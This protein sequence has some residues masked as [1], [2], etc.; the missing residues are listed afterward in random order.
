MVLDWAKPRPERLKLPPRIDVSGV[1]LPDGFKGARDVMIIF[2]GRGGPDRETD[3]LLARVRSEDAAAG[4]QRAVVVFDWRPWF[5]PVPLSSFHG[6]QV[7]RRLGKLLARANPELRSLHVMGTSAG[8]YP[9]DAMATAY[10][11]ATR[12]A[13]ERAKVHATFM[14][15]RTD[16]RAFR[17]GRSADFAEH[18]L[19]TDDPVPE[20]DDP[21]PL[22]YT[23][24]VT[25]AAERASFPLPGGGA[26]GSFVTDAYMN[27]L[28]YHNWPMGYVARHYKTVLDG[29]GDVV[30]PT[31]EELPRGT[32]KYVQ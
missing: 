31:H 15:P 3:D 8:A 1:A 6:R 12:E 17:L 16:T 29:N 18:V 32:V 10:T 13:P 7:G 25:G 30:L 27:F 24:D 4:L 23:L 11:L 5:G 22:C 20:T 14:D 19:N 21:L 9:A 2:H 28:G 26:T